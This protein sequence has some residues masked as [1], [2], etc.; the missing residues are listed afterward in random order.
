MTALQILRAALESAPDSLQPMTE[1][2]VALGLTELAE[3]VALASLVIKRHARAALEAAA[4]AQDEA[5]TLTYV[6]EEAVDAIVEDISDRR[7]LKREWRQID[8]DIQAEIKLTWTTIILDAY[9]R[10]GK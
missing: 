10:G 4:K 6:S 5:R 3:Q 9:Q 2:L 1:A 7:G 8:A